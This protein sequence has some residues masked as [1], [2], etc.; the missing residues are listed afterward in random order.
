MSRRVAI[1][2]R[3]RLSSVILSA[4]SYPRN[5][6]RIITTPR[7][8]YPLKCYFVNDIFTVIGDI[9]DVLYERFVVLLLSAWHFPCIIKQV[10]MTVQFGIFEI[11]GSNGELRSFEKIGIPLELFI[12]SPKQSRNSSFS[13]VACFHSFIHNAIIFAVQ[14]DNK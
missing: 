9:C 10:A 2:G 6:F 4:G 13:A 11:Y 3:A 1:I 12:I 5:L 8:D 7:D 14:L